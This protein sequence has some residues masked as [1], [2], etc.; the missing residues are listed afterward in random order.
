MPQRKDL[1][2]LCDLGELLPQMIQVC[3]SCLSSG[4]IISVCKTDPV[5]C[6]FSNRPCASP[7]VSPHHVY[8]PLLQLQI[9][10]LRSASPFRALV[11]LLLLPSAG[12]RPHDSSPHE[13]SIACLPSDGSAGP[14]DSWSHNCAIK[15]VSLVPHATDK[16]L[17]LSILS[18]LTYTAHY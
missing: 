17:H 13:T 10:S 16:E 18:L 8:H 4:L 11:T 9:A 5:A 6:K 1:S 7:T 14:V 3:L 12:H 15:C 2:Q